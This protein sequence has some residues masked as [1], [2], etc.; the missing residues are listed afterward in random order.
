[1]ERLM[2]CGASRWEQAARENP[3][4]CHWTRFRTHSTPSGTVTD[5]VLRVGIERDDINNVTVHGVPIKPSFEINGELD[6]QPLGGGHAFMIGDLAVKGGE[7]NGVIDTILANG[8]MFQAEHQHLYDFT[9][10]VWFIHLR[11]KVARSPRGQSRLGGK[12]P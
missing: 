5:G 7:I 8:L 2:F 1:M 3:T 12:K 6:F 10:I 4:D 9:P 11:G